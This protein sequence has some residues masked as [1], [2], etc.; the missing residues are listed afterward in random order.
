MST[1]EDRDAPHGRDEHGEPLTP[2]GLTVEG[3]P[4]KGNRGARPGQ[5][6]GRGKTTPRPP[7]QSKIDEHRR[8]TIISLVDM[9]ITTPL[10]GASMSPFLQK[11]L[12]H[13][14]TDALAGDAVL[15][16]HA[17]PGLAQGLIVLS[18]SK[19]KVLSWVD[20]VEENAPYLMLASVGVNLTKA[21]ISN[22]A[23]PNPRLNQAGR[24]RVAIQAEQMAAEIERQA[25][26]MGIQLVQPT[27]AQ[28]AEPPPPTE[29][30]F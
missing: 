5:R 22:H 20:K 2:F 9:C 6:Q 24:L 13:D 30:G 19:P 17:A 16:A 23:N 15:A 28:P 4:R 12:G 8:E 11:R 14:Q 26:E 29:P 7:T 3:K 1:N 25:E 21:I 18:Q 10:A 27:Y